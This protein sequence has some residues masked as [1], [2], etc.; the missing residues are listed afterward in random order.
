[1]QRMEAL[2]RANDIRSRRA[3]LKRDLKAGRQPIH[4]L[5]LEPPEYLETAK[6]FDLLLAVPKYGRV[7]VNKIL[8][9]VPD[10]AEQDHRRA[11]AAPADRAGRPDAPPLAPAGATLVLRLQT[12]PRCSSSPARPG[13]GRARS[14]AGCSS[15]CRELE[16]S[17]SATTRAPRPGEVDGR[18]YHFLT[19]ERVRA[20][21][22]RRETSSSTP[23]TPATA[24]GRCAPSSSDGCAPGCRWCS[25]SRCR[26]RARCARRCPRRSRC[27]SRRRRARRCGRAWSA[28][29][30]THPAQVDE[31]LRTAE[32]ELAAQREFAHVVVNDR[33]EQ[34]T[35]ELVEIVRAGARLTSD[36]SSC[37][38]EGRPSD[39]PPHRQ[40]ARPRRLRLRQRDRGGQARAPDQLLLPQPRRGHVRRVSAADGPDPRRRTT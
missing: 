39:L 9:P 6:V 37:P 29:G 20:P 1:M 24:T 31:R 15:A 10:L 23:S 13:S 36:G 32:R 14:S 16:L 19:P 8:T 17:V 38:N 21:R 30:P 40:A 12:W 4:E 3:Q 35:G 33:L 28:G 22:R 18:D 25:R 34:A 26:A 5:L 7:K 11:L 27:S 2:Q